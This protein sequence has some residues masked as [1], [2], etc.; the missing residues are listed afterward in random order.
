M[1]QFMKKLKLGRALALT[2][3]FAMV[4]AAV[5]LF[6]PAQAQ[7]A[8]TGDVLRAELT[9]PDAAV[10]FTAN[11]VAGAEYTVDFWFRND[12]NNNTIQMQWVDDGWGGILEGP[13]A[14]NRWVRHTQTFTARDS[15]F[16]MQVA[17]MHGERA[18]GDV[19][20]VGP[21]TITAA[22]GTVQ[23]FSAQTLLAGVDWGMEV[24][25]VTLAG[26]ANPPTGDGFTLWL[27]VAGVGVV[28]SVATLTGLVVAKKKN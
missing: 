7:A 8:P 13:S 24:S 5:V 15:G 2:T 21:I 11:M 3:A 6:S 10:R 17:P 12:A 14:P 25:L 18:A 1:R 26:Q 9:S 20:Y 28:A 22:D 27:I 23:R 19:F 4:L 16:T